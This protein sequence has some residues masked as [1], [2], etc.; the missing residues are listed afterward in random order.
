MIISTD[1]II[2][3]KIK[4]PILFLRK[5]TASPSD[6]Q[7]FILKLQNIITLHN[8]EK[9]DEYFTC[10]YQNSSD[11]D[12]GILDIEIVQPLLSINENSGYTVQNDF[13]LIDNYLF[14]SI[15]SYTHYGNLELLGQLSKDL[16]SYAEAN[17]YKVNSPVYNRVITSPRSLADMDLAVTELMLYVDKD[18]D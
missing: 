5:K 7:S 15:L 1:N 13:K 6:I 4:S 16:I 3:K 17:N 11:M 18:S 10:I 14:P 2:E 12:N 8:F 9:N